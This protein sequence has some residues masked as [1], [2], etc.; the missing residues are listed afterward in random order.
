[1]TTI[2]GV[3]GKCGV[4]FQTVS[5]VLNGK[6][7]KVSTATRTRILTAAREMGYVPDLGA[8]S[9][10][11][12]R[13]NLAGVLM[14][15]L[16]SQFYAELVTQ[17]QAELQKRD[18]A[19]ICAFWHD[20]EEVGSTFE[21]AK[22][23]RVD[24]IISAHSDASVFPTGIPLVNYGRAVAG[25]D[26]VQ[27]PRSAVWSAAYRYLR[28]LGHSRIAVLTARAA[29]DLIPEELRESRP[30]WIL[31]DD[32]NM[33]GGARMMTAL[34]RRRGERPT[35]IIAHSDTTAIGAMSVALGAG[36]SIPGDL[37]IIGRDDIEEAK[38]APVPLTTFAVEGEPLA[39]VLVRM[40]FER[41]AE[42]GMPERNVFMPWRLVERASCGICPDNHHPK[43]EK[44]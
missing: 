15:A 32:T 39:A 43:G 35:A 22:K 38:F 30:D 41:I 34:L 26:S 2:K 1:M 33:T 19:G 10:V 13:T 4:S 25:F 40:L 28:S 8:R 6:P 16:A 17:I 3:A 27:F 44:K 7:G 42:P 14:P 24:G 5:H 18:Y 31:F 20:I 12:R 21:L 23:Y 36:L 9:I 11:T 37:S 29:A